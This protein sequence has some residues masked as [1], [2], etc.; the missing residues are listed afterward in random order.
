M[1]VKLSIYGDAVLQ[2]EL[3]GRSRAVE[4]PDGATVDDLNRVLGGN[5]WSVG[6][7]AVNGIVVTPGA[8]L[9]DGDDVHF[10]AAVT[11]G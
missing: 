1:R 5:L 4:L 9:A 3:G 8:R 6:T 10:L 7:F 11:G 2:A